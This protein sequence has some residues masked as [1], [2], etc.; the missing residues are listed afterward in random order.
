MIPA[1][2]TAVHRD[3]DNE[4]LGYLAPTVGGDHVIPTTVFGHELAEPCHVDDAVE[5]LESTGLS[6]LADRWELLSD[7][8]SEP[9]TVQIVEASPAS[10]T[11]QSIDYGHE[12]GY[13]TRFT[14]A[15]PTG[16]RLQRR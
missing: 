2:W 8:H 9:M 13:G 14:L 7:A 12:G 16:S 15:A 3:D 5:V 6:Y 10:V 4:L 1:Q 11:V